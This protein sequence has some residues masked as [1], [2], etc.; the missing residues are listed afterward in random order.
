MEN[1]Q[2]SASKI[3]LYKLCPGQYKYRYI[4]KVKI[5]RV[6][7]PGTGYGDVI[8]LI[9]EWSINAL[10]IGVNKK[11]IIQV[12][13]DGLF[14][15]LYDAWLKENK[16]V[17]RQSRAYTYKS[18]IKKGIK[19]SI[20]MVKFLFSFYDEYYKLLPEFAFDFEY[21]FVKG[22]TFKGII[23]FLYFKSEGEY[24]IIDFKTTKH[25]EKFYF[26]DW[27]NDIQSLIYI[28]FCYTFFNLLP[29]DFNYLILNHELNFLFFKEKRIKNLYNNKEKYFI[30]LTNIIKD[31]KKFYK[32]QDTKLY[33]PT[34]EK[35]RWCDYKELCPK[36][37]KT[38]LKSIFK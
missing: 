5:P 12:L 30:E 6:V 9:L 24:K 38:N 11:D 4:D 8:H 33:K 1:L 35:C 2:L 27:D 31:I 37:Y 28:Y 20:M 15:D 21:E 3:N 26:V 34:Q 10:T 18:F 7:W 13:K 23:D 19:Q 32:K 29:E 22:I 14:Q 36:K 16:E 25:N 17:F